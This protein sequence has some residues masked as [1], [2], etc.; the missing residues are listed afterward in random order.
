MY[1]HNAK[2]FS[3]TESVE[4]KFHLKISLYYPFDVSVCINLFRYTSVLLADLT[5][6]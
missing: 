4:D 2:Q 5:F 1:A 3:K 6:S